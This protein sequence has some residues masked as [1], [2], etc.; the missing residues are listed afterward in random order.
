MYVCARA[1]A[2][3][4]AVVDAFLTNEIFRARRRKVAAVTENEREK[5]HGIM[6]R[7]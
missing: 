7:R 3:R 2:G 1:R 5:K 4:A 6:K